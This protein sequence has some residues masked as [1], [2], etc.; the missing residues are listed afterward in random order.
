MPV[1]HS[2][3]EPEDAHRYSIWLAKHG[4]CPKDRSKDEPSLKV[5]IWGKSLSNPVGLAAGYDKH[6]EAI[7]A[8]LDIGFGA[9][10]VGSVTPV[11]QEGNAKPRMF[12]LPLDK[13]VINR[14][15]FNS[16]GH[17]AVLQ[18]LQKRIMRHFSNS[19][20]LGD[21]TR[22][23]LTESQLLGVNLG[24]NKT[25]PAASNRDYLDGIE[26]LGPYADYLVI[27]ISSPNT[28]GLRSLQRREPIK[29]LLQEAKQSRDALLGN[30]PPLVV[31]I[32][33]DLSDQ[34]IQDIAAV[35]SD[36]GIDGVIISNTTVT[37]PSLQSN[38]SLA[39]EFGGLSGVPLKPLAL[40]VVAQ[41]YKETKG[42]IPIIGCGGIASGNDAV[43]FAKA[44]ATLVQIYTSLGYKGPGIVHDIKTQ[45]AEILKKENKT[46]QQIIGLNHK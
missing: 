23:S 10:E 8:I 16:D 28:P 35:V 22:R 29:R 38:K 4:F 46:W 21:G 27:N 6:A 40:H 11:P 36:V 42:L 3:L 13:A 37:R 43:E 25:S 39:N 30:K 2:L 45:V 32:S 44:G 15:G 17:A 7:D 5:S 41:F 14:Y 1:M 31:K 34:E 33:P 26:Q 12:R 24:K 19:A 20:E 18:R 9:V